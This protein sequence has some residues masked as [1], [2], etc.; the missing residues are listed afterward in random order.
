MH[1]S[2]FFFQSFRFFVRSFTLHPAPTWHYLLRDLT[3]W[4][5]NTPAPREPWEARRGL[6]KVRRTSCRLVQRLLIIHTQA[7]GAIAA[8]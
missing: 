5:G 8:K 6:L 4:A 2:A 3:E 7:K 1:T